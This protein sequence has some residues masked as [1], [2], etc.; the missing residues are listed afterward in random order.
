MKI[1]TSTAAVEEFDTFR[2][3]TDETKRLLRALAA[4]RDALRDDAAEA[5]EECAMVVAE[6][7]R[8]REALVQIAAI[9]LPP[10]CGWLLATDAPG[11]AKAALA[12]REGRGS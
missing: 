12:A 8:L 1:D 9:P 10:A 11:I 5:R 2:A 6:R 7:D 3:D 4:E